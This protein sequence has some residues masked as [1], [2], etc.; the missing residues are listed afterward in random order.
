MY[1][2]FDSI[3]C[4]CPTTDRK[5]PLWVSVTL[6]GPFP[7]FATSAVLLIAGPV[8]HRAAMAIFLVS[9][10]SVVVGF[11]SVLAACLSRLLGR[12]PS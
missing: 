12:K 7:L 6:F 8:T 9:A 5:A 1:D 2:Q 11:G 10:G 3:A 4:R